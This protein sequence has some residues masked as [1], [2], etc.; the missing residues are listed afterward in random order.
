[1]FLIKNFKKLI[2]S[3]RHKTNIY[4]WNYKYHFI[5]NF[6]NKL[7]FLF[8]RNLLKR[9]KK[10]Y[11]K[12][13]NQININYNMRYTT[14]CSNII[15]NNKPYKRFAILKNLFNHVYTIPGLENIKVGDI[16]I[17]RKYWFLDKTKNIF[18]FWYVLLTKRNSI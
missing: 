17:H 12:K 2:P 16:F 15:F 9:R 4:L 8:T 3:Y 10:F 11:T 1:M 5:K 6:N 13:L 7:K 18:F 14:I